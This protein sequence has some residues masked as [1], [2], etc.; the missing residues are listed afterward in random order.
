MNDWIS[1]DECMPCD[2]RAVL[3]W[4]PERRNKYTACWRDNEWNHFGGFARGFTEQVTHWMPTPEPPKTIEDRVEV[5]PMA[6][7]WQV[8]LD[9]QHKCGGFCLRENAEIYR[10]GLIETMKRESK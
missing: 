4:C 1:V 10:I 6:D 3:V 7:M 9:K 5:L 2:Y 8:A